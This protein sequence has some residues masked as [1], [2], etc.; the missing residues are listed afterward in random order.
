MGTMKQEKKSSRA[1]EKNFNCLFLF[2]YYVDVFLVCIPARLIMY[3]VNI[4]R[5]SID[6]SIYGCPL[7]AL[8][9]ISQPIFS[10]FQNFRG[11]I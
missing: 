5:L 4:L 9:N 2:I 7:F 1:V 6:V 8:K 10:N 11:R 3:L